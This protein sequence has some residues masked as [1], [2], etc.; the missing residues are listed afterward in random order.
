M[1]PSKCWKQAVPY[2]LNARPW[3]C[4]PFFHQHVKSLFCTSGD[5]VALHKGLG[6]TESFLQSYLSALWVSTAKATPA[7]SLVDTWPLFR[8]PRHRRAGAEVH[9][10]RAASRW[11]PRLSNLR[12]RRERAKRDLPD[13]TPR[14]PPLCC[15]EH[16]YCCSSNE[17]TRQ[18]AVHGALLQAIRFLKWTI[19]KP[20]QINLK[21]VIKKSNASSTKHCRG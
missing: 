13:S 6:P 1:L 12:R 5:T 15:R 3:T 17:H 19:C 11:R 9:W 20:H 16:R 4:P 2:Q 8:P 10:G 18:G 7:V 14:A 21:H